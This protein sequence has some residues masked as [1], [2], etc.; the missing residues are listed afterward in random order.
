[1]ENNENN[2]VNTEEGKTMTFD[3]ILAS[4]KDY[5]SEFDSRLAKS[6]KTYLE[7]EKVKWEKEFTERLEKEKSEAEKLAK[8]NTEQQLKYQIDQLKQE[9]ADRDGK[10]NASQL[11]DATSEILVEKGIPSS[12]L[13]MFD[14]TKETADSINSKVELLGNI[15]SQDLQDSLNRSLR[16]ESPRYV[17]QESENEELDPYIEGF[18]SEL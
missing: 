16:Q 10:L 15:R 12:Y 17:R 9:L 18:K 4:N 6:N 5:Q 7:N 11:K 2:V 14:F 1:M 8:M 3:E 13:N